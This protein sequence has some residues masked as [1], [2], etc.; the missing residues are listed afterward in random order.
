MN[1]D[2][3]ETTGPD[4]CYENFIGT[5]IQGVKPKEKSFDTDNGKVQYKEVPI[6]YNYGSDESPIIDSCFFELP[7]VTCKGGI[8]TKKETKPSRN[9]GD[10]PYVK[11][12]HAMM[13]IF[14]LQNQ[15]DQVCL[16]KLDELHAGAARAFGK[17]KNDVGMFDFDPERPGSTFKNPVY[18]KR[19]QVT[20]ERVKSNP[21]LWVKLNHWKNNKT[22]FTDLEGNPID[23]SLLYD[24]E[25]KL[26]PLVHVEKIYVGGG[27]ASLQLKLVSAI[28]VDIAQINTR[29]RQGATLTKYKEKYSNLAST[30]S[31]QLAQLRMEKQDVLDSGNFQPQ[32]ASL[33]NDA[34]Q[35]HSIPTGNSN[36]QG[37]VD[38]LNDFLGGA[39]VQ[40]APVQNQA[41]TQAP[42]QNQ[43][44]VQN[45]SPPVQV[46]QQ[47]P[48]QNIQV[49]SNAQPVQFNPNSSGVQL[50]IQ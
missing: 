9:P 42:V 18:Y 23:W 4:Y 10:P 31:S 25:L 17:F 41:P 21:S 37:N 7:P 13:V 1:Q 28:I 49:P 46:Q 5:H 22:L 48:V 3:A 6:Q 33:P 30:V 27:K 20:G 50:Q 14:D 36:V 34:G 15:D 38:Q 11:E 45:Q 12:S 29:T 35:M 2:Q 19:D 8:D 32:N 44:P 40:Q 39:P 43:T 47:P 16:D 26:I 24:V